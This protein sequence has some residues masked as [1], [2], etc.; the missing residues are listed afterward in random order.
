M[1]I[2]YIYHKSANYILTKVTDIA[3]VK[4][5][6]TYIDSIINDQEILQPFYEIVDFTEIKNYDFGYYQSESII[7]L[8]IK[9][10]NKKPYLGTCLVADTDLSKG[11]SNIFRVI[12]EDKEIDIKVFN[13]LTDSI[14]YINEKNA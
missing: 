12:G 1:S 10:K 3:S 7:N 8:L 5:V 6:E 11:M 9:L 4:Q 13:S 14:N 2:K